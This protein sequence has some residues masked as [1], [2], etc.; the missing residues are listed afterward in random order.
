[1]RQIE[2]TPMGKIILKITSNRN[3]GINYVKNKIILHT[4]EHDIP[5]QLVESVEILRDFNSNTSDYIVASFI[6]GMGD[7][8]KDVYPYRDNLNLTIIRIFGKERIKYNYKFIILNNQTGVSGSMY[9][10]ASR[11]ELNKNQQVRVVGQCIERVAEALRLSYPKGIYHNMNLEDM[12]HSMYLTNLRQVNSRL[13]GVNL[14]LTLAPLDNQKVY[15]HIKVP[16]G[17]NVMNIATYLQEKEY[18]LYNGGIGTYY[19][20]HDS[21]HTV[22]GVDRYPSVNNLYIYPL[23]SNVRFDKVK[24][25]LIIYGV[26]SA[27]FDLVENTY[28]L[29]GDVLSIVAGLSTNSI[30]DGGNRQLE[31]GVGFSNLDANS[32]IERNS[33]VKDSEVTVSKDKLNQGM[34]DIN[35]R[36]QNNLARHIGSVA[37]TYPYRT[38]VIKDTMMVYQV[39]WNYCDPNLI[40]PGMPVMFVYM[41]S[42]YGLVKLKGTVQSMYILYNEGSNAPN[43]LLNIMVDRPYY[44]VDNTISKSSVYNTKA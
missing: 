15:N 26:S 25:N 12:A 17:V 7:F 29:D 5:I 43:S 6:M 3:S 22:D 4:K 27:K 2:D 20:C 11:D 9:T 33:Q 36:D 30:D 14:N 21:K 10:N 13:G 16:T 39:Q 41:D 23:Y 35:R 32:I 1:M 24:K 38:Q 19:L 42:M 34:I 31:H 40:Y 18:G 28:M 44:K 37:N 8:I